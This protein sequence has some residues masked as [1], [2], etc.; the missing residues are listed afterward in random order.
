M[1]M[2]GGGFGGPG[3]GPGSAPMGGLGGIGVNR[4]GGRQV[5]AGEGL[6]FA[7]IP[8]ELM[9][10]VAKLERSEPD[11]AEPADTFTHQPPRTGPL[12]MVS[13]IRGHGRTFAVAVALVIVETL[14]LQAGPLLVQIGIDH[15]IVPRDFDIVL[16]A[17]GLF[18][19]SVIA[20]WAASGA[21]MRQTGRLAADTMRDLRVRVFA[22]LQRLSMDYYTRE[23]A[24]V[25]MT[26]M[27]SDV[28]ALQ[29][30]FQEGLA[31][32]AVQG[33]TMVVVTVVL[34]SYNVQL[35]SITLF[36][37]VPLL[38]VASLWFRKASDVGYRRQRDTIGA[39]F[40]DLSENL[41]GVRVI[42]AHNR[43]ERNTAAHRAVVGAY[44][45]ANDFTGHINAIYGPG[46]SVIGMLGLAA[47]LLI[48]GN[49]VLDGDLRIGELTAFV[50]YLNAFFAPVQQ[51]VQLY[52]NYQQGR[53][54][55]LKL[56]ELLA[57]APTVPETP[58]AQPLPR[59]R[60]EIV[61]SGVTFGYEPGRP[62]LRDVELRI[63]PGETLAVVGPTGAGKST[64]AKLV[65]RL[66]DPDS[67]RILI[68]GV[69]LRSVTLASLRRQ[70][71]VV[72]QEPFMFVGS[73]RDNIAFA[74]P[75]AT[76]DEIWSAVDAVGLR[77]LVERTQLGLDAP[78][79]ERGQS[80]SSGQRQ[81]LALARA[82]LAQPR[83]VVLDEAT[84]N[85]D[86]RSELLVERALDRLL[87]GRTALLIAHRLSTAMRADR[88][89]VV[90]ASGILESGSH[91]ELVATGGHYAGMYATWSART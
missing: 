14:L 38:L 22:Q 55:V 78:L 77:E 83:V 23:K 21:R 89:I 13:L 17:A 54:A 63:A 58:Q 34:F 26:R 41:Y 59:V 24:G 29:Q 8:A 79:H 71:G 82:F 43:Q 18:A 27:T 20:G 48:G 86:L 49:M 37:V 74:R 51:L 67:G 39:M 57:A 52:T 45:D 88:I 72:P 46:T 11:H 44:R 40:S 60:G 7:G 1:S 9:A 25:I 16:L 42:T 80:V 66:H 32:F 70:I 85:L 68:D 36:L 6:P 87:D 62:V 76:D 64:L 12:T 31:Q 50:L 28:E 47:L 15:G 4:G 19:A 75:E 90:D 2:F 3:A 33:L 35:A 5:G 10:G 53:A 30:L 73:L 81:L 61:F 56:R 69:D 84:S 91:A 65:T